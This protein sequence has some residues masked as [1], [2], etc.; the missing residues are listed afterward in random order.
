[1][2][3]GIKTGDIMTRD[4]VYVKP[5]TSLADCAREMIKKRVS[6]LVIMDKDELIGIITE[7]DILWA[8]TKKSQKDLSKIKA[9]DIAT[10]KVVTIK[11]AADLYEA[12]KKMEKARIRW[13]PVV[14]KKKLLGFL[15]LND[16]LKLEPT[17]FDAA[18]G[19]IQVKEELDKTRRKAEAVRGIGWKSEGICEECG[20]YD[21]LYNQDS[22]LMCESCRDSM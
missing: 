12:T 17:L 22:R 13:L 7:R 11:P 5:E 4:F 14:S 8:M 2:K 3:I 18:L 1:M 6:S 20:N 10:K 9:E 16:I 21:L 15:T 19:Y